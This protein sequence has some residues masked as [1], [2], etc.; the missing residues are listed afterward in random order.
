MNNLSARAILD[1]ELPIEVSYLIREDQ[2]AHS[3]SRVNNE[4]LSTEFIVS[5]ISDADCF[6]SISKSSTL[7]AAIKCLQ[8]YKEYVKSNIEIPDEGSDD[9]TGCG[10]A[11]QC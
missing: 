2:W 1:E 3:S 8:E 4:P 5:I 7:E 6:T 9:C 10:G 11:C